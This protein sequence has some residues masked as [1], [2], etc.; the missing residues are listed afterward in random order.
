MRIPPKFSSGI[1]SHYTVLSYIV[2]LI[3]DFA[4]SI[5]FGREASGYVTVTLLLNGGISTDDIIITVMSSEQSPLSAEGKRNWCM[6]NINFNWSGNGVD[7]LS[8]PLTATFTAGTTST[9]INISLTTDNIME[10]SET[11][12]LSFTI[13][14][15]LSGQVLSG[16]DKATVNITDD[17]CKK[18]SWL[19]LTYILHI[20]FYRYKCEL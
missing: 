15:S 9:A 12:D 16:M 3:V 20:H 19:T 5:Y 4:E 14:L 8:T 17:T 11:F 10:Q 1:H 13:P 2:E 7:Y 18:I 6:F